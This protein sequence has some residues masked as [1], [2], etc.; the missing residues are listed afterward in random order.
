MLKKGNF[1]LWS[2]IIIR[3]KVSKC[4]GSEIKMA[5]IIKPIGVNWSSKR[6]NF[7]NFNRGFESWCKFSI[8]VVW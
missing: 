8:R 4:A 6:K 1:V 3:L 5:S 2:F 7:D